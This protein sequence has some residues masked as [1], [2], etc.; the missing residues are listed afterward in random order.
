LHR[1]IKPLFD[2]IYTRF[3]FL[4]KEY[5]TNLLNY[6]YHSKQYGTFHDVLY[7]YI[8]AGRSGLEGQAWL[9]PWNYSPFWEC[10]K[11]RLGR[12]GLRKVR[13]VKGQAYF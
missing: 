12:V 13:L 10:R 6:I 4:K 9:W 3:L 7:F 2:I 11:V 1:V 5:L 8:L